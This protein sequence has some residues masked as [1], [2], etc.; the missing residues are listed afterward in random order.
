MNWEPA[1]ADHSIDRA[2]ATIQLRKAI[3][4]NA[5]D[6]LLVAGRKAAAKH[7]MT[8]RADIVEPIPIADGVTIEIGVGNLPPR[9]A[10]FRRLESSG[11][12]VDELAIGR[13][14]VAFGTLRY[15]RWAD[16][17]TMLSDCVGE[18]NSVHPILD[19]VRFV[20]LE[21]VDRFESKEGGADHFEVI[22]SG[23]KFI[24]PALRDKAAALHV[25]SGWFDFES[26]EVRMLTQVKVD[27]A[28]IPTP[29]PPKPVRK[30]A[31]STFGQYEALTGHLAQPLERLD[32]LH[33]Y[34]KST[35]SELLT[36][37]AAARVGLQG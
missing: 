21:Y 33:T 24:V 35:F 7:L 23:S 4:P 9:R 12:A 10:L 13:Q 37:E 27:V 30:L 3:D 5:L 1:R 15:R 6:E 16:F 2:T 31:F 22:N 8:D 17:F 18:L 25:H 36:P 29:P 11:L 19:G 20:R 34:L 28:D 26:P 14:S 32:S